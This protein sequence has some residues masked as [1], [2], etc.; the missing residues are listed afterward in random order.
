MFPD[1]NLP[2]GVFIDS[3]DLVEYG[4]IQLAFEEL[5]MILSDAQS[6]QSIIAELRSVPVQTVEAKGNC[7]FIKHSLFIMSNRESPLSYVRIAHA[8][9]LSQRNITS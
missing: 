7:T 4:K 1:P 8:C 5:A 6:M 2:R 3:L 9:G